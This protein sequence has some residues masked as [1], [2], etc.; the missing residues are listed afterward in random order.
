MKRIFSAVLPV[1]AII[2]IVVVSACSKHHVSKGSP[3]EIGFGQ[4]ANPFSFVA[5]FYGQWQWV[6]TTSFVG[7]SYHDTLV[8][9]P[10][11]S[12][13]L[14]LGNEADSTYYTLLNGVSK[15]GGT[16]SVRRTIRGLSANGSGP[17]DTTYSFLISQDSIIAG[18][19]L[20]IYSN[21]F[22]NR[23]NDT[24]TIFSGYDPG[25]FF[26]TTFVKYGN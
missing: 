22:I 1:F 20:A 10:G 17:Y 8:P 9:S 4:P 6:S 11:S 2:S 5:P 18:D 12:V 24:L 3:E 15:P 21:N 16:F 19:G 26:I 23:S 7:P 13:F 25:G 14:V